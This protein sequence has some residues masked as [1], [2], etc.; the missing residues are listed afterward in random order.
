MVETARSDENL[1]P[2][3]V[4]CARA[5]CTQGEIVEALR[6]VFGGYTETPRF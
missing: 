5:A 3:L 6:G 4:E 2:P 1:V